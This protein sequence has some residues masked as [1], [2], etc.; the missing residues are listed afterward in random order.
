MSDR[1]FQR[2][3]KAHGLAIFGQDLRDPA[4]RGKKSHVQHA[5]GFVEHQNLKAL[6]TDQAAIEKVFEPAR[7]GH[8]NTRSPAQRAQLASFRQAAYDQGRG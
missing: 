6:E 3:R 5:V 7:S 8:H 1:R 4:Q 2:G